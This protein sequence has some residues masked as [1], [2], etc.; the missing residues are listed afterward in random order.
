VV[1]VPP[2]CIRFPIASK[3]TCKFEEDSAV[4]GKNVIVTV[5]NEFRGDDG[6]GIMFGAM[7]RGA[8]P[9][10]VIDGGD[11]PENITSL[12]VAYNPEVVLIA[13]AMDF[14]GKPGDIMLA[15]GGYIAPGGISTHGT[16]ML[17]ADY[18]AWATS[19][20]VYVLG[21]QPERIG[22]DEP[23]S[24]AVAASIRRMADALA[25]SKESTDFISAVQR[26][27]H[28]VGKP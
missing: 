26:A 14:G 8:V 20:R 25:A 2:L 18:V 7:V 19:A 3:G 17:F 23:M 5:G 10:R 11:A 12:V 22:F 16:L 1:I 13:D 24:P 15:Q 6:S 4:S 27:L 9:W 28:K 21:F